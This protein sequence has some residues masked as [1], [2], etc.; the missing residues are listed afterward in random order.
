MSR[1][2]EVAAEWRDT[3]A[4]AGLPDVETLLEHAPD[5][6]PL[7]GQLERLGKPGLGGRERWRWRFAAGDDRPAG[8]LYLKRYLATPLRTQFDRNLRQNGRCSAARWEYLQ[9]RRLATANVPAAAPIAFAELVRGRLERRSVVLLDRVPGDAFDRAW[10]GMVHRRHP[11][12][13]GALR[14]DL[15]RRLARFVAAFHG[16]G[17]CHRDLYL[18]HIFIDWPA[19]DDAPPRFH[20][21][22]L[23]R[24]HSPRL[25]RMRWLLKDLSQLDY[26]ADALGLTRTDRLRF[27]LAYLGLE[28]GAPRTR[29]YARR[30]VAR[31]NR[32]RARAAR[33]RTTT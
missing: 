13:R 17:C 6:L 18:C 4:A 9:A 24:V 15:A 29:W 3:L 30:I 28:R 5:R 31:S 22:D 27:L 11:W 14:R 1:A 7:A 26:S 33:R 32:I 25:R 16:T 2:S 10:P 23:T 19:G 20:L 21:I 8:E 12:V